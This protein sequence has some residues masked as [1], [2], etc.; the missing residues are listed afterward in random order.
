[1]K[2]I[3]S[4]GCS[5]STILVYFLMT[6]VR[7]HNALLPFPHIMSSY[8]F[9]IG[10]HFPE[11]V[12]RH[13]GSS[14]VHQGRLLED[15]LGTELPTDSHGYKAQR[16]GQGMQTLSLIFSLYS[17]PLIQFNLILQYQVLH[18]L[19]ICMLS[20]TQYLFFKV[21]LD[22]SVEVFLYLALCNYMM[23]L[24]VLQIKCEKYW[25]DGTNE[26]TMYGDLQ[27]VMRSESVIGDYTIRILDVKLVSSS[28]HHFFL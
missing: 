21:S 13:S 27:V 22:L 24:L 26:P 14:S 2:I 20:R 15:D 23:G 8:V 25:P 7:F 11:R 16:K 10:L 17:I 9:F 18:A 4:M 28:N 12:H 19:F 3:S 5:C 1:M 6:S